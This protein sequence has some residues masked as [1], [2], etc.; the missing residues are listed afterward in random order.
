[1]HG[2]A[3][4]S[5]WRTMPESAPRDGERSDS[6]GDDAE[7][8]SSSALH[9]TLKALE[10]D[11]RRDGAL[12]EHSLGLICTHDLNGTL[13]SINPAAARALG[14]Q[15][16]EGVGQNLGEF[17]AP[18]T[19]HL[20]SSYL[21]RMKEQGRDEGLMRVRSREGSERVWLYRNVLYTEPGGHS[22]VLGHA[23]DITD[24]IAAERAL[25]AQGEELRRMHAE[26]DSRVRE[27]T[28]ELEH[29]NERLRLEIAERERAER[30]REQ[31]LQAAQEASRLKD[32]FLGTLSHEL[33][34][35]LNAIFGWT[36]ILRMRQLDSGTAQAV[37]VIERNAQAQI[38][39]IEDVLDVSRIISGKMALTMEPVDVRRVLGAAV[40]SVR[41]AF[42]AKGIRLNEPAN[43]DIPHALGDTDRLQQMFWN[44]LSNALKFTSAGGTTD[45][46][47]TS[48]E[49]FLRFEI[50]DSGQGIRPDVLPFIFD[51]FRQ[52]DSS[53]TRIHGGLGLGLAIVRHIVDL[54]GGTVTADSAGE[55]QGA[56]FVVHLPVHRRHD[57]TA[58]DRSR[59]SHL[60]D[61]GSPDVLRD[62][63]VLVI[64]DHD[65]SRDLLVN[66]LEAAGARVCAAAGSAEA[67]ELAAVEKPDVLVVDIGLPGEDGY[68]LL[69]RLRGL[70][71]LAGRSIPAVAVTAYARSSDR[72]QAL[73][74]GFAQHMAKPIDPHQ[75]VEI[76]AALR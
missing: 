8:A 21:A 29:A 9:Q 54:H 20:F 44:L 68:A 70:E 58:A 38:R 47:L 36:R 69:R 28:A 35:P 34:T 30:A 23:L 71:A 75:L 7:G 60:A 14:Y 13:L 17:L 62:L 48:D 15:P 43:A 37:R 22:Y 52:A 66:V 50:T 12:V 5:A 74:A 24:R 31:A 57:E 39:M 42:E 64:E 32:E 51:R 1:M 18:E 2:P 55:D 67:L 46:Q 65:D 59:T 40:D 41:P 53:M 49:E 56:T 6:R 11:A 27:R 63:T 61:T 73:A 26:L 45:L 16:N 4:A 10:S 33:R 25:H 19:R 72:E 3:V 76:I